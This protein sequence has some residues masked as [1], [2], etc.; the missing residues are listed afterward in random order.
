M[1]DGALASAVL[2]VAPIGTAA[3]AA[4]EV[5][6][7]SLDALP[8]DVVIK[9]SDGFDF[10]GLS[11]FLQVHQQSDDTTVAIVCT[12]S[13]FRSAS[14]NEAVA[15]LPSARLFVVDL[16][17]SIDP[18][19]VQV[20]PH[21]TY[22]HAD[23]PK[24]QIDATLQSS[25]PTVEGAI[26]TVSN[27]YAA[28]K[29][30]LPSGVSASFLQRLFVEA[31]LPLLAADA[32]TG[33]VVAVNDPACELLDRSRESLLGRKQDELHPTDTDSK[34]RDGFQ[35]S[36]E[37]GGTSLYSQCEDP[38][39]IEAQ[40]GD[41]IP[42]DIVDTTVQIDDRTYLLGAFLD[43][44]GRME[45]Q[46]ELRRRSMA[47]EASLTG[48][49]VL[50]PDGRYV[51]MNEAHANIFEY[52]PDELIGESWRRL[53]DEER[54]AEI[55]AGPFS[56]L[57]LTGSWEGELTG[58]KRDGSPVEQYVSLTRL[59]D[60]GLVCVNRDISDRKQFEAK[61]ESI[62]DAVQS[63]M[64]ADDR[65][66]V[67]DRTIELIAETLD[68]PL[69]GY[70]RYD[71]TADEFRAVSLSPRS[72]EL[73]DDVPTFEEGE[74]LVWRA[75]DTGEMEYYPELST[76]DGVYNPDT[77]VRSELHVPVGDRGVFLIGSTAVD[78]ISADDQKLLEVVITHVRTALTLAEREEEV[79][80]ARESVE[81]ERRQLRQVIDT[82]PQFV[83]AKN[84][85]GEFIF[86]NEAVAEAYGTTASDLE[87]KT[88]ADFAPDDDDVEAFSEDDR[89]VLETGK[90][91][92]RRG[93]T[94]T[95]VDG[96]ERVLD[97]WKV[98][99]DPVGTDTKGILGASTDITE[100]EKTQTSL[101]RS[102]RL[103]SLYQLEN[104]LIHAQTSTDIY[105]AGIDAVIEGIDDVS[106]AAY[107]W[108]EADSALDRSVTVP[109]EG[110]QHP[111]T[112][113]ID[114]T[115]RWRAFTTGRSQEVDGANGSQ[116]L[117]V[118]IGSVGLLA[119]A[120]IDSMSD[121]LV[122]FL[123]SVASALTAALERAEQM[124]S[125]EDLKVALGR[126]KTDLDSTA[127][128][129]QTLTRAVDRLPEAESRSELDQLLV[130]F[131]DT[132][133]S[134][135]WVGDYRP[136]EQVVV[137]TTVSNDDG[138]AIEI[139][140]GKSTEQPPALESV[141]TRKPV[142]TE[143]TLMKRDSEW[144]STM[145]AY[146]YQSAV[147]VPITDRGV[148]YGVTEVTSTQ[149]DGFD[150]AEIE[151][152]RVFCRMAGR[153]LRQLSTESVGYQ[154]ADLFEV[155]L[156]F[157][158]L[159]PLF[160]SPPAGSSIQAPRITTVNSSEKVIQ[161]TV[162]GIREPDFEAYIA[163][164]PGLYD[165]DISATG[166]DSGFEATVRLDTDVR[167]PTSIFFEEIAQNDVRLS[168]VRSNSTEELITITADQRS[169]VRSVVDAVVTNLD[170]G[171]V[172]AKRSSGHDD[173][174]PF[175]PL[176]SLT[177]RQR[178][179]VKVA[180][181]EG[182]YDQPKGINGQELAELFDISHSTVHEHLRAA[183]RRLMER[184][185]ELELPRFGSI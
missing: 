69:A 61:L 27:R 184:S 83:F 68:Q 7:P 152:L 138:P 168:G 43:A 159:R 77:P 76:V 124:S 8:L 66:S 50:S 107:S 85:S 22:I 6:R 131:I 112:V 164:T 78:N 38:F 166:S 29:N 181:D 137:P 160:P 163:K 144:A 169:G 110:D 80:R 127:Q 102:R 32:E 143:R 108:N 16:D 128:Q 104:E 173:S 135:G 86:A 101:R 28:S 44:S 171:E 72:Q 13:E 89:K 21:V 19:E 147:S 35:R 94:L 185:I 162:R 115:A 45:E 114:N 56:E 122:E 1:S 150:E 182:Y 155:D 117:A 119:V 12:A 88:D 47:M 17:T 63:F 111:E 140:A 30:G 64:L 91:I 183:E 31:P 98:P 176:K 55:E 170:T 4:I 156:A 157:D 148:I 174:D 100:L 120:G 10:E 75:F 53:Y 25:L 82:V 123:E 49:S 70:Y 93:E 141:E 87:G 97:T 158:D 118:P 130:E 121:E 57:E 37:T 154:S 67:I 167:R 95:D 41:R 15:R 99:F 65:G 9:G 54:Q 113:T 81:A 40:N 145:L 139:S 84:D 59:S 106:V 105:R 58:I 11:S 20:Q 26:S 36:V 73:F 136:Q 60:G 74:G 165:S 92:R 34:Y 133:W 109:T 62:R 103:K 146:G 39:Y 180:Y 51:Y 161:L 177:D 24:Q 179:I 151:V 129:L 33:T 46:T 132:N 172:V 90:A 71:A 18:S 178:E 116:T 142:Y 5:L 48:I 175:D 52:D 126:L 42:I 3:Q 96:N 134:Y 2:Q 79:K 125:M 153:R 14:A 149:A 23:S